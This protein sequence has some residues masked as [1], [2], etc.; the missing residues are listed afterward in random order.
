MDERPHPD[1]FEKYFT[2]KHVMSDIT[3]VDEKDWHRTIFA[4]RWHTN[5]TGRQADAGLRPISAAV[6]A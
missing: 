4:R 6:N 5:G 2:I 3:G 1:H